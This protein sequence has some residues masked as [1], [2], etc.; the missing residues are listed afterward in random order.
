MRITPK[1]MLMHVGLCDSKEAVNEVIALESAILRSLDWSIH[2]ST[3]ISSIYLLVEQLFSTSSELEK[4]QILS[5]CYSVC[6]VLILSPRFY[7][8][9]LAEIAKSVLHVIL[10]TQLKS[11]KVLLGSDM[12]CKI[13]VECTYMNGKFGDF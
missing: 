10:S 2:G 5:Q 8:F 11:R 12:L 6:D 13:W 1:Q 7:E 9:S 3:C 4:K